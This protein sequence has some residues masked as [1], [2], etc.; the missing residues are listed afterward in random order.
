MTSTTVL[1]EDQHA[2]T[3]SPL[4]LLAHILRPAHGDSSNGGMS[5]RVDQVVVLTDDPRAQ[6]FAPSADMPAVKIVRRTFFG[7]TYVHAEPAEPPPPGRVGWMFG[8]C[9]LMTSDGRWADVTGIDYPVPLHDRSET[10][11]GYEVLSR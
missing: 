7:V 8:G 6:V 4:G 11:A 2:D 3:P 9:Y 1:A 10:P 5:S